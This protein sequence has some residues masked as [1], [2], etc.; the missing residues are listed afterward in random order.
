M[1]AHGDQECSVCYESFDLKARFKVECPVCQTQVCWEC[2]QS[3][4][5]SQALMPCCSRRECR[6]PFDEIFL[7][8]VLPAKCRTL[9][10][11]HVRRV[12]MDEAKA[13]LPETLAKIETSGS[14]YMIP[15]RRPNPDYT[16]LE[17]QLN[18]LEPS[19][20]CLEYIH[21]KLSGDTKARLMGTGTKKAI[22]A[23]KYLLDKQPG[24]DGHTLDRL[25]ELRHRRDCMQALLRDTPRHLYT[26][27]RGQPMD[28]VEGRALFY[29]IT[30]GGGAPQS[31]TVAK[32]GLVF[33]CA[34]PQGETLCRGMLNSYW[35]CV[36]CQGRRCK[37]CHFHLPQGQKKKVH[38]CKP[39]DVETA[40]LIMADSQACPK[41]GTRISR[42]YGCDHMWCTECHT[43][44]NYR[45]GLPIADSHN[46]NPHYG[47]W[48]RTQATANPAPTAATPMAAPGCDGDDLASFYRQYGARDI[49]KI[50]QKKGLP[51]TQIS[52]VVAFH[53]MIDPAHLVTTRLEF[54]SQLP[55]ILEKYAL[56]LLTDKQFQDALFRDYRKR[57]RRQHHRD[58]VTTLQMAGRDLL[59]N[60]VVVNSEE[61]SSTVESILSLVGY[62]DQQLVRVNT[63]LGYSSRPHIT[64]LLNFVFNPCDYTQVVKGEQARREKWL[65]GQVRTPPEPKDS[66]CYIYNET[67]RCHIGHWL[68]T[69]DR[70]LLDF[71]EM[72]RPRLSAP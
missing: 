57:E 42:V 63:G 26:D 64:P 9:I 49:F 13:R 29:K 7:L 45:T 41:C 40:K 35:R 71:S 53:R 2:L 43:S 34:R 62:V 67:A 44:F 72:T 33:P 16:A 23:Y 47:Q 10:R 18:G 48:R 56:G 69:E 68:T 8:G 28:H 24:R 70:R 4:M 66:R 12:L 65:Y 32:Q 58:I 27:Y 46:T 11:K 51:L 3:V 55:T 14:W 52:L 5:A 6:Q 19:L 54:T 59:R 20:N 38:I 37:E 60:L 25:I 50:C 21:R 61:A 22:E 31:Q 17:R 15:K 1:A 30:G 39:E 36:V